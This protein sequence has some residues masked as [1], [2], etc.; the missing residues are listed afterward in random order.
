MHVKSTSVT[1]RYLLIEIY[2][3]EL[4]FTKINIENNASEDSMV[5]ILCKTRRF[6]GWK[7]L[8][9]QREWVNERSEWTNE[10]SDN[11]IEMVTCYNIHKQLRVALL[12]ELTNQHSSLSQFARITP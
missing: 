9:G 2:F 1:A 6:E 5:M 3:V 7:Y 8:V 4:K 12:L 11:Y 10:R